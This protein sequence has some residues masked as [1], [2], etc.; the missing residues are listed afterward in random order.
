MGML[1]GGYMINPGIGSALGVHGVEVW[2]GQ[3]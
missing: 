1:L 3:A 2:F